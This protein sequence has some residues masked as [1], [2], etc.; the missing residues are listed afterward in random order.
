M[1]E[2][3]VKR[4]FTPSYWILSRLRGFSSFITKII[5][6]IENKKLTTF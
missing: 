1:G 6:I 3:R 4:D 5:P 2:K